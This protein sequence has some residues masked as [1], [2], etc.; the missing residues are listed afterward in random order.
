MRINSLTQEDINLLNTRNNI[1]DNSTGD[2]LHI[3]ATNIEADNYNNQKFRSLA[4]FA[5]SLSQG[6]SLY[7][8]SG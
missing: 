8:P 6:R 2:I 1:Q 3:F 7:T 5:T 4:H